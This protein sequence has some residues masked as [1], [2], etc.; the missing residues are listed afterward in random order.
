[1]DTKFLGLFFPEAMSDRTK[2]AALQQLV[3]DRNAA[4]HCKTMEQLDSVIREAN[5]A[6]VKGDFGVE[7]PYS[8]HVHIIAMYDRGG[9]DLIL[10]PQHKQ[11]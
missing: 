7:S 6:I 4:V 9:R 11:P 3:D 2:K 10:V 5:E 8:L 1:M